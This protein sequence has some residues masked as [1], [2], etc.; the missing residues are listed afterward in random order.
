MKVFLLFYL[1]QVEV[2]NYVDIRIALTGKYHRLPRLWLRK[3]EATFGTLVRVEI[4][5]VVQD[6]NASSYVINSLHCRWSQLLSS[7]QFPAVYC[8]ETNKPLE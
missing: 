2:L 6:L 1:A 4:V 8:E 5:S 7:A 3:V